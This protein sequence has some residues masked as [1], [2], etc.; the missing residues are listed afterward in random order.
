ME[1]QAS[2]PQISVAVRHCKILVL[3]VLALTLERRQRGLVW[4]VGVVGKGQLFEQ[5]WGPFR[6]G[7]FHRLGRSD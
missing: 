2:K 3:G 7:L 6:P 5:M 4:L 1:P